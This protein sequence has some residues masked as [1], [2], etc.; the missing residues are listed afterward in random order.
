MAEGHGVSEVIG[1]FQACR[2]AWRRAN[3]AGPVPGGDA[4]AAPGRCRVSSED[5][6][7]GTYRL[8]GQC[9]TQAPG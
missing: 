6:V 9:L 2:W 4:L 1:R 3:L 8:D 5:P 7:R